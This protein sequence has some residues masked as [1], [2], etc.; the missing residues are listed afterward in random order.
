MILTRIIQELVKSF[1]TLHKE[2][3]M[4]LV[5]CLVHVVVNGFLGWC[6]VVNI[7]CGCRILNACACA[8]AQWPWSHIR[9]FQFCR[10]GMAISENMRMRIELL[11]FRMFICCALPWSLLDSSFFAD[12]ILGLNPALHIPDRSSFF[13]KHLAQEVSAWT[14]KFKAFISNYLHL[15]LSFD[16]WSTRKKDEIYTFHTTTPKH[17]SFFYGWSCFQRFIGHWG[18]SLWRS[19]LGEL[20]CNL[21]SACWRNFKD[22]DDIW[23][24]ELQLSGWRWWTQCLSSQNSS[25]QTIPLATQHIWSLP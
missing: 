1:P 15:T 11:L 22:I 5:S 19:H 3:T 16:G 14:E 13:P 21:L 6:F 7:H 25:G 23:S 9:R 10:V 24:W 20:R 2:V 17:R 8:H 4:D 18:S 12:F